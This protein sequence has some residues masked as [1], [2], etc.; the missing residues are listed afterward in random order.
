MRPIWPLVGSAFLAL[1]GFFAC[2]QPPKKSKPVTLVV[3]TFD[4][5]PVA[6]IVQQPGAEVCEQPEPEPDSCEKRIKAVLS[7][8]GLPGA[9]RLEEQRLQILTESKAEPVWFATTPQYGSE[10]VSPQVAR[11][12]KQLSETKFP[13]DVLARLA[14]AF[15]LA[16]RVGREVLLRE[17]YLF[18]DDPNLARAM[19]NGITAEHLFA[20][21][22]IWIRRGELLMH[23]ERRRGL[24]YYTDG[25]NAGDRVTLLLFDELGH[26]TV[27]QRS[28]VR[29]FRALQGK[30]H[31]DEAQVKHAT[32]DHLVVDLTYGELTARTLL[33]SQG[34]HLTFDC[35]IPTEGTAALLGNERKERAE[36][37]ALVQHLR[38]TMLEEVAEKLPFDEPRREWGLQLD[39]KLRQ[40]WRHAYSLSRPS[41]ALNGDRYLV[42]DVQGRPIVPQVCVDF[43]TDTLERTSGT[44]WRPKGAVPGRDMGR[45]DFDSIPGQLRDELRRVPVFVDYA[46]RHTE[47]F[48]VLDLEPQDR[49]PLGDRTGFVDYLHL[50]RRD[51]QPGDIVV[52]R[53]P[54]PWDR[55]QQHYHSFFV[56]ENDPITGIPI[57]VLGNAGRPTVRYWRVETQ[58]TP[59]RTIWHRIRLKTPWLRHI[60]DP[61]RPTAPVPPP[62]SPRGNPG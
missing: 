49:V 12:R 28:L 13:V 55:R 61:T 5:I 43:L 52:I 23:A 60:V 22:T 27:P 3:P 24:Y 20:H 30:L 42:F 51:Y 15:A 18:A 1:A 25:P 46:R 9:P 33:R 56:Y 48:E 32:T 57:A 26:D 34:A 37:F 11:Y 35:E 17:G 41:F 10:E 50:H 45:L 39:G 53:G 59:K 31:F 8:S 40:N 29:D 36:R 19:V 2:Q 4:A 47:Q 14:P 6:V 7:Q 21:D 16:P 38:A 58:R 44:W 54:T 62:L